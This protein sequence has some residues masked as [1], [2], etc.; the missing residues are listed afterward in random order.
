ASGVS[1]NGR[2]MLSQASHQSIRINLLLMSNEMRHFNLIDGIHMS[3]SRRIFD[4]IVVN[5]LNDN[6]MEGLLEHRSRINKNSGIRRLLIHRPLKATSLSRTLEQI[7]RDSEDFRVDGW[8][9][10]MDETFAE[11]VVARTVRLALELISRTPLRTIGV[12]IAKS[13]LCGLSPME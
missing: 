6:C 8:D 5:N 3:L 12:L 10:Y 2:M 7:H 11:P 13:R 1:G 9:L 4:A